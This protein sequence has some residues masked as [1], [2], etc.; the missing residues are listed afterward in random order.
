MSNGSPTN[1]RGGDGPRPVLVYTNALLP[2]SETFI[3]DQAEALSRYQ[4]HYVGGHRVDGLALPDGRV[5]V[6]SD[7]TARGRA[8]EGWFKL[9]GRAPALV[10]RLRDERPAV[11]HAHFGGCAAVALPLAEALGLPFVVTFHGLDATRTVADR[12]RQ[13]ALTPQLYVR[14]AGRLRRRADRFVTITEHV[15]QTLVGQGF[16]ADRVEVLPLGI[17]T[18]FFAPDAAVEREPVV[19]FVGRLVEKKGAEYLV[20]AMARVG[21]AVPAARL[22]VIG[23]GPLRATL[24]AEAGR[25]LQG[26]RFLGRRSPAEVRAW[27]NRAR[28]FCVP[29]VTAASGDQE[30]F[31]VVFLEAQAMG[32]PVV[33][34]RSGGIPEAVADGE[35]GFLLPERDVEGLAARIAALL[36]DPAL[37][38]A[39][40]RRGRDRVRR[41]FDTARQTRRLEALYDDVVRERA[42]APSHTGP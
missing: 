26:A 30:G 12:R 14:R 40:S 29:S 8:R 3:R 33:S 27:M 28:V 41:E 2:Y 20:R 21:R 5:T 10:R 7:G 34:S 4:A 36:T 38:D 1:G 19:L 25:T 18:A 11:L 24:E 39:T 23:D 32:T 37:W 13:L 17:D 16:P 9:S 42:E 15:R 31:G 6:V 35:T 22:V